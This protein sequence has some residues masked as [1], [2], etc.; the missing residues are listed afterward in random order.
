MES[1]ETSL[2]ERVVLR[3]PAFA[4]AYFK[5]P[6]FGRVAARNA[7]TTLVFA[8]GLF[9]ASAIDGTL[10]LPGRD[11]GFLEHPA[12]FGYFIAQVVVPFILIHSIN[13]FWSSKAVS[14]TVLP[15][16]LIG[17]AFR[18]HRRKFELAAGLRVNLGRLLYTSATLIGLV[19]FAW[20]SYQNQRPDLVG[21]NFWDSINFPWGYWSTRIYKAYM[22][23]FWFPAMAHLQILLVLSIRTLLSRS[24]AHGGFRLHPYHMDGCGGTGL[25]IDSVLNPLIAFLLCATAMNLSAFFIHGKFDVTTVGGMF[26]TSV[27]FFISYLVPAWTLRQCIIA[28]KRR[29]LREIA[30]QQA[31]LYKD[32]S[33]A[34]ST[35]ATTIS[36]LAS[37]IE[38]L[39]TVSKDVRRLPN[40][41]QFA[42]VAGLAG[43]ASSSPLVA[44]G[45]KLI[46]ER[47]TALLQSQV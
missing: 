20:N 24:A 42:R 18:A 8:L 47:L 14:D 29:Q 23:V 9:C 25:F 39:S 30:D 21:E 13:Q 3:Y 27:L 40:W 38:D 44:W 7:I 43:L 22:W 5:Y 12:I 1:R 35:G 36:E 10:T 4:Y 41:P 31:A 6:A 15:Q 33:T 37:A 2:G 34:S 32:L 45:T 26:L 19:V 16:T 11:T 17:G 46:G 28:E